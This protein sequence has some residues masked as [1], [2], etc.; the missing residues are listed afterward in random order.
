MTTPDNAPVLE[1]KGISK[2]GIGAMIGNALLSAC[3]AFLAFCARICLEILKEI[4]EAV[5]SVIRFVVEVF[6]EAIIELRWLVL[7]CLAVMALLWFWMQD[8][9]IRRSRPHHVESAPG[10]MLR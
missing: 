5:L 4:G 6:V 7:T 8:P 9:H 2:P 10:R 3:Q 1:A